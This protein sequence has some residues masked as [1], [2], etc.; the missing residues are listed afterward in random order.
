[1]LYSQAVEV[2]LLALHQDIV[3]VFL[4]LNVLTD[5]A[6]NI[7]ETLMNCAQLRIDF[8]FDL[9]VFLELFIGFL[10][11]LICKMRTELGDLAKVTK[12]LLAG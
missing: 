9:A 1:M 8:C 7:C 2:T 3:R 5:E 10:H 12:H 4:R 6:T 11:N